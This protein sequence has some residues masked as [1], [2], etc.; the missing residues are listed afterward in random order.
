MDEQT[1]TRAAELR[2]ILTRANRL[3][4]E[5]DAPEMPD[6]EYDRLFHEL[7]ALEV[8]YPE[9]VTP[10][11]PTQHVGATT[12]GSLG[13][14]EADLSKRLVGIR[15]IHLIGPTV[16]ELW[17][18][19]SRIPKR[20]QRLPTPLALCRSF[21]FLNRHLKNIPTNTLTA[22]IPHGIRGPLK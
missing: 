19:F 18:R 4:H 1:R 3:Y 21:P 9:L 16:A 13:D 2:E 12:G 10:D 22:K 6:A 17:R 8:A 5:Q 20:P 15:G 11:S 7:V 14:V